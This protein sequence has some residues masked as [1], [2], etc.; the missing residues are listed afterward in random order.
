MH[1]APAAVLAGAVLEEHIRKL[2]T[3]NDVPVRKS[4]GDPIAFEH[5]GHELV[6]AE[7]IR[8]TERKL[9]AGWYAQRTEGAHGRFDNV[10]ADDVPR[11]I[12]SIRDFMLRHPA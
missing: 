11:I 1:A 5:V 7:V 4:N 2:A 6:K 9:M 3:A 12:E 10:N 8:E